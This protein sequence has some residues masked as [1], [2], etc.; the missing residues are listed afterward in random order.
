[1]HDQQLVETSIKGST[2]ICTSST[3]L[4]NSYSASATKTKAALH[5]VV[6][7]PDTGESEWI[8]LSTETFRHLESASNK[9]KN[10][11]NHKN[12]HK[13]DMMDAR[14]SSDSTVHKRRRQTDE[15]DEEEEHEW[16]EDAVSSKNEDGSV[17]EGKRNDDADEPEDEEDQRF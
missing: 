15:S 7:R 4:L 11:H 6:T 3:L 14:D 16:Q 5:E 17:Y 2:S 8:D 1:M 12:K 13:S 10:N 9:N